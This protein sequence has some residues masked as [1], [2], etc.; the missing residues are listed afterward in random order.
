MVAEPISGLD[1]GLDTL[2][3]AS[4]DTH[5]IPGK[6]SVGKELAVHQNF[7]LAFTLTLL[8][9]S[10]AAAKFLPNRPSSRGGEINEGS[11]LEVDVGGGAGSYPGA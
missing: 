11:I 8:R 2:F 3:V 9:Q 6:S 1:A 10:V 5:G 4:V 7:T